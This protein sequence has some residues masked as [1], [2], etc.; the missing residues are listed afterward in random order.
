MHPLFIAFLLSVLFAGIF[1][2]LFCLY[3]FILPYFS[4][5]VSGESSEEY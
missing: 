5:F 1:L 3:I 2:F 4:R